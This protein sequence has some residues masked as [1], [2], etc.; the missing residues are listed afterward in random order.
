MPDPVARAHARRALAVRWH[1]P[2]SEAA[3]AA[4][5]D[6]AAANVAAAIEAHGPALTPQHRQDLAAVLTG[7]GR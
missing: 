4:A 3:R 5:A 1:G 6:L 2:D 7:A